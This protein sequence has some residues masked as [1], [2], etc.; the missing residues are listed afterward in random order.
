MGIKVMNIVI[1]DH[2]VFSNITGTDV[3]AYEQAKRYTH[4]STKIAMFS[5]D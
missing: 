1:I 5:S 2:C 4:L 3:G